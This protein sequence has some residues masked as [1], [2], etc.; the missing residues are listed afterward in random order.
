MPEIKIINSEDVIQS[1]YISDI[2]KLSWWSRWKIVRDLKN[3]S[4]VVMTGDKPFTITFP[5]S[6]SGF[7][8]SS[9]MLMYKIKRQEI[10]PCQN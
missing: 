10:N 8:C 3:K 2:S 1:L 5:K 9:D 6:D 4:F 7:L